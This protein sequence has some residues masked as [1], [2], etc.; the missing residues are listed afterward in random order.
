MDP[1]Y[2]QD[3]VGVVGGMRAL[4]HASVLDWPTSEASRP[5]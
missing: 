3:I 5:V 2:D 1:G 4:S